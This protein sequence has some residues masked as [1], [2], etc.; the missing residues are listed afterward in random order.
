VST[1]RAASTE[2][3]PQAFYRENNNYGRAKNFIY[4][5]KGMK[6]QA[7]TAGPKGNDNVTP[8]ASCVPTTDMRVKKNE[9]G[10]PG[11][12]FGTAS[13]PLSGSACS[14]CHS[15][16]NAPLSI[17]FRRF[18][19]NGVLLDFPAIDRLN[20]EDTG[21]F[22]KELL[23]EILTEQNSCWAVD[24]DAP[25]QP[26][27]G[28]VGLAEIAARNPSFGQALGVQIPELLSN[29]APDANMTASISKSYLEG[30]QTL[31]AAFKGLFLSESYRCEVKK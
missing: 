8:M 23:K 20:N 9:D 14:G 3:N 12:V 25:P 29:T 13:V 2:N 30:G 26:F 5:M 28:L 7:N 21:G 11:L 27:V 17:A 24:P 10:T 18:D 15:K 4:W 31:K 22:S 19:P 6:L 16:Y 1:L